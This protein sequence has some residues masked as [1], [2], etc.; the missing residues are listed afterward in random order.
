MTFSEDN[1]RKFNNIKTY[2][3]HILETITNIL[4]GF[5]KENVTMLFMCERLN[6][7]QFKD[8]IIIND[9][10]KTF[11]NITDFDMIYLCKTNENFREMLS[12]MYFHEFQDLINIFKGCNFNEISNHEEVE[13]V[14]KQIHKYEKTVKDVIPKLL[15]KSKL[16]EVYDYNYLDQLL[17]E[18]IYT[19]NRFTY[20]FINNG[21]IM[22]L[23]SDSF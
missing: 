4:I 1:T 9:I 6:L 23:T 7:S 22:Q 11:E 18:I 5:T 21:K 20:K 10:I 3:L 12:Y 17:Q 2:G 14:L 16:G 15:S 19:K 13:N 8:S